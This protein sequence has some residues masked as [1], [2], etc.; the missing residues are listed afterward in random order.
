[1][2]EQIEVKVSG[3][4]MVRGE[5]RGGVLVAELAL[6][7][8]TWANEAGLSSCKEGSR[9]VF[10]VPAVL[11]PSLVDK[12][13][14]VLSP[15]ETDAL[16]ERLSPLL[17][18]AGEQ[19]LHHANLRATVLDRLNTQ[20]VQDEALMPFQ[21]DGVGWLLAAQGVGLVADDMGLGK[22]AQALAW[23]RHAGVRRTVVVAPASVAL[24]WC[25]EAARFHPEV[26]AVPLLKQVDMDRFAQAP[27]SEP[28]MAVLTWDG[29]RR[30]WGSLASMEQ[31]PEAI[32]ADEAHYAK[33]L[34]AQRT[35]ALLWL[36]SMVKHRVLLS[37]TPMRNRPRELFPLLH[38]LD[39]AQF[40]C[41]VPYG[42]RYCGPKLQRFGMRYVR[43]YDG[44]T[45][46]EELNMLLRPHM[47]RRMKSE[48]LTQ[49]PPKQV[50]RLPL[51]VDGGIQRRM[52]AAMQV[53]RTEQHE[54]GNRGLGMVTQLRQEVGMAKV[55][56]ALEWLESL[57]VAEEPA[58]LF[59]HHLAVLDA[60]TTACRGKGWR[61]AVIAGDTP[62][63]AR[64]QA[65]ADFQSGEVDVLLATEAAR[66]GITLTRSAYLAFVEYFWVPGD[67]QQ[68]ADRV[69]RISQEREVF[70]TVLHLEGSLDDHV[71][72]VIERK[73]KVIETVQ[74]NRSV[75]AEIIRELLEA[76]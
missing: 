8:L 10:D 3:R 33:S 51:P 39:P 13:M 69:W 65:V 71:A 18:L 45:N 21:R 40:P 49:L 63:K 19:A 55:D 53:L 61:H 56:A 75:E 4:V 24:N 60:L 29:L 16:R 68:A 26:T 37:G 6:R 52:K 7:A 66:E 5:V 42:E 38:L 74:D 67:M 11:V 2:N 15:Q 44:A 25:R 43:T 23:M 28:W 73:T 46:P 70:I 17:R 30:M 35:R 12:L 22:T 32:V 9:R 1:M 31:P 34:E 59:C 76:P 50:Q 20:P 41:F 48:V 14:V 72:K 58:V 62:L 27:P 36:G 57:R 47:I 64:Q 54:G